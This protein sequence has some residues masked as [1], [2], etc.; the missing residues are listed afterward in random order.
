[1]GP[2]Q[3]NDTFEVIEAPGSGKVFAVGDC[4]DLPVPK[5]AYLAGA[6]G[7]SVAKQV[8]A[9][10]AGKPLKSA[11]PLVMPVSLV[12]VGKTGGV[13]SLPMGIVVGDF[14]TR[15]IKSKDMFVSKYW[16]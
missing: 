5:I 16:T 6:E 9:S 3:V 8:A 4:M 14:M 7:D 10:A 11:A 13:S 1:R 12:P 15:N 2:E